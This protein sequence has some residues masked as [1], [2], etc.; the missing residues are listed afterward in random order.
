MSIW[1]KSQK[2]DSLSFNK[3]PDF[4]NDTTNLHIKCGSTG[5][6]VAS[7][8]AVVAYDIDG[9]T[10]TA[11]P[12]IG[13]DEVLSGTSNVSYAAKEICGNTPIVLDAGYFAG[14]TYTWNNS[15]TCLLYT[16]FGEMDMVF[17]CISQ[18]RMYDC[19]LYTSRCV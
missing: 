7:K 9:Q 18:V 4:V 13:A 8:Q 11:T 10:R 1:Q 12:T 2:K 3:K 6:N 17:I 14:A 5:Y 19:L 16:S 15:K